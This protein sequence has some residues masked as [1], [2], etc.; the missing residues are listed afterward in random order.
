MSAVVAG[1]FCAQARPA[2]ADYPPYTS[3]LAPSDQF[4]ISDFSIAAQPPLTPAP[5]GSPVYST[6][7]APSPAQ[8]P[9]PTTAHP[10]AQAIPPEQA[11]PPQVAWGATAHSTDGP[12]LMGQDSRA[13]TL[14]DPASTST[15]IS[16]A[17]DRDCESIVETT[18]YTRVDYFEWNETIAGRDFVNESG[19]IT[20]LG[21]QYRTG[22]QRFRAEL[23]GGQVNY[24]AP[25]PFND[26]LSSNTDYLGVRGEYEL[27]YDPNVFPHLS[28]FAGLGTRYWLRNLPGGLTKQ[29]VIVD[30]Y[31]EN[32]WSIYPY[33]GLETRRILTN[34]WEW[35]G[36]ARIGVDALTWERASINF[37][38]LYPDAGFNYQTETGVRGKHLFLALVVEGFNFGESGVSNGW[39]QPQSF[40][41]T[42][43]LKT[44]YSF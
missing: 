6:A 9:S 14:R 38:A 18:L 26:F 1:I 44:G 12:V 5:T 33:I 41:S 17:P 4:R 36:M 29:N 20:T 7:L 3:A 22:P 11:L 37:T 2:R 28:L 42:I 16:P 10:P 19:E 30:G 21:W 43:G 15:I 40:W 13:Y 8:A 31:Q 27:I 32:W 23:F 24:G 25:M 35:Y 39:L 34:D